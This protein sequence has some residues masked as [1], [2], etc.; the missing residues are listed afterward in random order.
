MNVPPAY[1]R[2]L[3]PEEHQGKVDYIAGGISTQQADAIKRASQD[4]P[5]ELVFR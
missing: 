5:L 3:P 4:Y 2:N 1:R